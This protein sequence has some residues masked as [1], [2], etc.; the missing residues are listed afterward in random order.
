MFVSRVQTPAVAT[1][2]VIVLD[3]TTVAA[4]PLAN[5]EVVQVI[6]VAILLEFLDP[7]TFRF[8]LFGASFS[9]WVQALTQTAVLFSL[10]FI[11]FAAVTTVPIA[12]AVVIGVVAKAVTFEDEVGFTTARAFWCFFK[13][14]RVE[15]RAL[16]AVTVLFFGFCAT[17]IATVPI[18]STLVVAVVALAVS[19]PGV[20]LAGAR[21]RGFA[22]DVLLV[23]A[24]AVNT[25]SIL[26]LLPATVTAVPVTSTVVVGI[27]TGLV[28]FPCQNLATPLAFLVGDFWVIAFA[29]LAMTVLTLGAL[30]VAAAVTAV[31]IAA[32]K[33][34][35]VVTETIATP[36]VHPTFFVTPDV[37]AINHQALVVGVLALAIAAVLF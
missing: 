4:V 37:C 17:A 5:L 25:M 13:Y 23:L 31:P 19:L 29:V 28:P 35:E 6:A 24:L 12:R 36:N 1:I 15:A 22:L 33:V 26:I 7:A 27:V 34:I 16:L 21:A 9:F 14:F 20:Y 32:T 10:G 8:F 18:A 2:S 11:E 30:L 3:T